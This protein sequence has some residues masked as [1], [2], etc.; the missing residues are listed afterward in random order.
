MTV[1]QV[2]D[3]GDSML[4]VEF[5]PVVDRA[6]NARVLAVAAALRERRMPGVREV[7]ATL[8]SVAVDYDPLRVERSAVVTAVQGALAASPRVEPGRV[9]EIPVAYGGEYGPDLDEVAARSGMDA[10]AAVHAHADREYHAF[11]VGF[12]PGFTYLGPV[13][14]AIVAPRR[15]TPRLRVPGGS[16][17][18]AGSLTG[19]YPRACPGGW[20][21]IGR[22]HVPMFDLSKG[23]VVRPGDRVR[24]VPLDPSDRLGEFPVRPSMPGVEAE[25]E[26]PAATVISPGLL[27]TVQDAGR[28]GHQGS[29]VP[30]GG[31]L[32]APARAE[33][34]AAVGNAPDAAVLEATLSG[35]DLRLDRE[36]TVAVSG[37]DLGAELDGVPMA[38]D[39]PAKAGAGARLRLT[40]RR[41][42]MRAYVA[43]AGGLAVPVVLGSRS[44][45][46]GAGFGGFEGRALRAGD[47]LAVDRFTPS[48]AL[49]SLPRPS[50]RRA[51]A[52]PG[53]GVRLRVLVGP[54]EQWFTAAALEAL[55][56]TRFLV[57]PHSNR[58]GYRLQGDVPLTRAAAGE[59]ISDA[60]VIG[61]LQVPHDGQPILLMADRQVTGGYP[62]MATV[63]TADLPV[64]GQLAPGDW[65]RFV[66]CAR[67]EA[68]AALRETVGT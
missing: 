61:G 8:R 14:E 32:D 65:V 27:T 52:P 21:L 11:M 59:M 39:E 34:N 56:R 15:A 28:W 35:L 2:R 36:C 18:I 58:V 60:T 50:V 41:S 19:V 54:H 55:E 3:A 6:V 45:E 46:L 40:A 26:D 31:A 16:V 42:G 17:G 47:R 51:L 1:P 63:I 22:T 53:G 24:F 9:I 68:L 12:M 38:L 44:T 43:L 66:V 37:A 29:G 64:A 49:P 57:T 25:A 10:R 5:E 48:A 20:A 30:V 4:L 13:S 7:R 67:G 23:C 33:A 62:I